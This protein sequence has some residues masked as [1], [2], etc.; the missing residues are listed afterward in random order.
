MRQHAIAFAAYHK[1]KNREMKNRQMHKSPQYG[2]YRANAGIV[3]SLVYVNQNRD[4]IINYYLTHSLAQNYDG[5]NHWIVQTRDHPYDLTK[6][7]LH[8]IGERIKTE[9]PAISWWIDSYTGELHSAH[10]NRGDAI[11]DIEKSKSRKKFNLIHHLALLMSQS[12]ESDSEVSIDMDALGDGI[13]FIMRTDSEKINLV[14][15]L[16]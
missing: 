14:D 2:I 15:L 3:D 12:S 9:F 13:K 11:L 10:Y 5:I 8:L 7:N 4:E 16:R 6:V 1:K